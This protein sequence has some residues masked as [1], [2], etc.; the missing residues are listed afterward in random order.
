M[1]LNKISK[2]KIKISF[3]IIFAASIGIRFFYFP[4]GLP[5]T[6]DGMDNF[7]YATAINYYGH[8][9]TEWS[10]P[11]N[12]W[13]IFVSFWFSIV[14]LNNTIQYMQLQII[15]SVILSSLIMIPVY[16]LCKKFFDEKISL[17]GAALFAFDPR[18][19]QNSLLGI[20]EPLFILLG[21]SSLV[22]FLRYDRRSIIV[23]FILAS[24]C[25]IV[26]SEGIFLFFTLTILFFIRYRFSREIL[27]TYL[28][29]ILIFFI[30][31]IPIMNYRI[32]VTGYDGIFQRAAFGTGQ[33]LSNSDRGASDGIVK[34]IELFTKYLGWVMIPNF[35]VFVP[36]GFI[37]FLRTRTKE[38]NFI[39]IFLILSSLPILYAY[40]VEAQDTRYF[41][42]LY[43]IFSL[44]SLFA[45]KTYL[46]KFSKKDFVISLIIIGIVAGSV[47]F[48]EYK[49]VDYEKE[50][51]LNDI[52]KIAAKTASGLNFHPSET[53]YIRAAELPTEW[54]FL[55][56]DKMHKIKSVPTSNYEDL[57]RFIAG[58]RNNLTHLIVDDDPRL[59]EFLQNV[60]YNEDKYEYLNKVFD[61]S[62]IGFKHN[63]KIF[64]IDFQKFDAAN[65]PIQK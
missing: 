65:N 1:N 45:V 48:Y 12:G 21:I 63:V 58:S 20:T 5:L 64:S 10:P 51:E 55:F 53:R 33:I 8:L 43:P 59:P 23:S 47:T 32:E 60:Y 52:A 2:P 7:T 16:F 34:G 61:S 18:I 46:G 14:N 44:I 24:F 30:M 42:F 17:V 27:K 56:Y 11:N 19:I 36:F 15:I 40:I 22:I 54:P 35:L 29:S 49:K 4:Y 62:E 41:Y 38:T 13:P 57:E 39:I 31:L 50:L 37:Q 9:P 26:R 3:L 6:I 25:T 28:P